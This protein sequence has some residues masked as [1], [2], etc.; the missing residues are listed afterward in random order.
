MKTT[1]NQYTI[2]QQSE[3]NND[4]IITIEEVIA[5]VEFNLRD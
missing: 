4:P 3:G 5:L 1:Q 2:V